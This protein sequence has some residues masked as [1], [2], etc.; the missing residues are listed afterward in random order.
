MNQKFLVVKLFYSEKSKKWFASGFFWNDE[1]HVWSDQRRSDGT[2]GPALLEVSKS[3]VDDC[4]DQ[5]FTGLVCDAVVS[6]Y[7]G[8][9]PI[10]TLEYY[11]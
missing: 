1:K 4:Q 3:F 7:R 9:Y 10:F 5:L 6:G 11:A 2:Y 8:Q